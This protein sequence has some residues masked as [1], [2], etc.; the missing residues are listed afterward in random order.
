M[1][2][3]TPRGERWYSVNVAPVGDGIA[4]FFLDVSERKK[5][6]AALARTEKLAA[7]GRLAS[8]ISHEIN[9]PLESV[10]NLLYLIENSD[11][12]GDDIRMYAALA[13][14]E[15]QRVS[16]I[17]TPDTEVSPAIDACAGRPASRTSS[18]AC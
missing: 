4:I 2:T 15:M 18:K 14:S 5:Q 6:E 3:T 17:V 13:A 8:S 11:P 10:V 16:H 7:V 1:K 12:T 9:N